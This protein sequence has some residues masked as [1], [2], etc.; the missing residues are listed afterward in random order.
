MGAEATAVA[1]RTTPVERLLVEG[2]LSGLTTEQRVA[3]YREVCEG[4]GLNPLTKPF[5]YIKLN[6]KLILYALKD[7][8]EQ[9]RKRHGVSVTA[10]E[11]RL[12][13]DVYVVTAA[14]RDR[15]GRDD[16]A[17]GAVPVKGLTGEA[18]ANAYMKAETKCKRR[19]TLSICGLGMLDETEVESI[20]GAVVEGVPQPPRLA[21]EPPPPP[22]DPGPPPTAWEGHAAEMFP[23][24]EAQPPPPPK[25][26]RVEST[27]ISPAKVKRLFALLH[28][29]ATAATGAEKGQAHTFEFDRLK[30]ALH[31]YLN[32]A[33]GNPDPEAIHWREYDAV[34]A[35]IQDGRL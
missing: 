23:D 30:K 22:E 10:M 2:D 25:Q 6:G 3:Y 13:G 32:T 21:L 19:G 35:Q 14:F 1:I 16:Q 20:P 8:T 9:L 18:L 17:T 12:I 34:C 27:A 26:V 28:N 24:D 15:E 4:L 33:Y 31:A 7:C 5:A 29:A 11:G